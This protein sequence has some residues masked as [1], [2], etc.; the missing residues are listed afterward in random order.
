MDQLDLAVHG[1]VHDSVLPAKSLADRVGVGYQVLLNKA[2]PN[3][4]G[5]RL[6]LREALALMLVSDNHSIL[7]VMASE[8]GYELRETGVVAQPDDLLTVVLRCVKEQ[9]DVARVVA[10]SVADGLV[11]ARE[12]KRIR[13]EIEQAKQ[14]LSELD[15]AVFALAPSRRKR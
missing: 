3:S 11:C 7:S 14:A 1:T 10:D 12:A 9:G 15:A 2:N 8:L 6:T 13:E 5:H 4:D